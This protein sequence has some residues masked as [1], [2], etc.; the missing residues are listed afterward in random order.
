MFI[1]QIFK[2]SEIFFFVELLC[3]FF[4]NVSAIFFEPAAEL[5]FDLLAIDDAAKTSLCPLTSKYFL[6]M[7]RFGENCLLDNVAESQKLLK[8]FLI[9]VTFNI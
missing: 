4:G 9:A 1:I 3:I 8:G 6:L 7:L 5:L 2:F